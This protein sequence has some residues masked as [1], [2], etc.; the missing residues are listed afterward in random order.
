MLLTSVVTCATAPTASR[1]P[2]R[3][4]LSGSR[5][6][7]SSHGR[8]LSTTGSTRSRLHKSVYTLLE[9]AYSRQI[10]SRHTLWNDDGWWHVNVLDGMIHNKKVG[11]MNE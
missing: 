8:A 1:T 11:L 6:G 4:S 5:R 3:K 10:S 9:Y 7:R 2:R